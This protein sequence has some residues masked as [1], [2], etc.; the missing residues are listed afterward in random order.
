[1]NEIWF[2]VKNLASNV[3]GCFP[4]NAFSLVSW[5]HIYEYY[6]D[7][8]TLDDFQDYFLTSIPGTFFI[9]LK[10]DTVLNLFLK[11]KESYIQFNIFVT[12]DTYEIE[13]KMFKSL[14]E[15]VDYFTFYGFNNK[16]YL[17]KCID[18]EVLQFES[19][20]ST[21]LNDLKNSIMIPDFY[22]TDKEWTFSEIGFVYIEKFWKSFK[23]IIDT[24]KNLMF[25]LENE[26]IVPNVIIS[27][28]DALI[29]YTHESLFQNHEYLLFL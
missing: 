20:F 19:V 29:G 17:N 12:K 13:Q 1:M 16:I 28:T 23:I 26:K 22:I 25:L 8:M 6:I 27:L 14:D 2:W 4:I 9:S 18:K 5:R 15:L 10:D 21:V 7:N 11:T 24:K 3:S